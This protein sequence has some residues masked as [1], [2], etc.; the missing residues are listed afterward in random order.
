MSYQK[1]TITIPDLATHL[2]TVAATCDATEATQ[3]AMLASG[4]AVELDNGTKA[5]VACV[6]QD[7]PDT[8][9]TEILTIALALNADNTVRMRASGPPLASAYWHPS[10]PVTLDRRGLDAV[11]KD[12]MLMALGEQPVESDDETLTAQWI[13]QRSIRVAV[14]IADAVAATPTDVL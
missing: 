10:D 8:Y 12:L 6:V 14:D 9:A 11:R 3:A 1:I 5:W 4:A 7:N 13:A 2:A